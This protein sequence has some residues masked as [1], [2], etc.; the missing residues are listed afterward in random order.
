[1][2][3][4]L[5]SVFF[6]GPWSIG[7]TLLMREKAVMWA[8]ENRTEKLVFVVVRDENASRTSLLEMEL[9]F[10]FRDQH[11]L[12]NVEVLGLPS[13]PR[14]TLS[15]LLKEATKRSASSWMV[16]ELIMPHPKYH[17]QWAQDLQRLQ[18]L[19]QPL[20]WIACAGIIDGKPEHF[21]RPYLRSILPSDFHI[22]EMDLPLRNTK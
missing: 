20:L 21:K 5:H 1:M 13:F 22:P 7:K 15:S 12:A 8:R 18:N 17:Q 19:A 2:L 4:D 11:H 14:D 16:D 6:I 3:C 10:F 9:R